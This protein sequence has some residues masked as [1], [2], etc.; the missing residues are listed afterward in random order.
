MNVVERP[1]LQMALANA[2]RKSRQLRLTGRCPAA[3]EGR[4]TYVVGA[5]SPSDTTSPQFWVDRERLIVVR[6]LM[7]LFPSPENRSQD[8]RLENNMRLGGG[9]LATRVRIP[10]RGVALQTE[11]YSDWKS[12]VAPSESFFQVEHW[13]EGPHWAKPAGQ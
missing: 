9:W 7:P 12:G 3:W 8:V 1:R 4:P 10:D 11:D 2:I 13:S 5:T 6:F